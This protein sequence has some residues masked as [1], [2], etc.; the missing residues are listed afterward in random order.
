MVPQVIHDVS[1]R[2]Q[3]DESESLDSEPHMLDSQE[4]VAGRFREV[5]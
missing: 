2:K 1:I 3:L 4:D 5:E